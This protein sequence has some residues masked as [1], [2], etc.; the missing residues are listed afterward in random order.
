VLALTLDIELFT[1]AHY[2]SSIE[3]DEDLSELWKDVFFFHWKEESQHAIVDELEWQR[4]DA[5]LDA[6]QRDRGVN[7]LIALVTDIDGLLHQQSRADADHFIAATGRSSG[8]SEQ[9]MLRDAFLK[10]YR[11]QYIVTGVQDERFGEALRA[12]V[13]PSQLERIG[14]ALAP[15]V[16][17]AG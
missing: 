11:W 12:K 9:A 5:S 17:H 16:A 14:Q 13:S 4:V 3:A 6:S 15:I 8:A 10:A 1:Q 7:D 2:R